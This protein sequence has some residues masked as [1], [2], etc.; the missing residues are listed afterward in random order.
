TQHAGL[1]FDPAHAPAHDA[2]AVDHR[3]VR[4]G[5]EHGVREPDA[6]LLPH[7]ARE[8]LHVDLVDDAVAGR[9]YAHGLERALR[10]FDESVTLGVA[11]EL[12]LLV[13]LHRVRRVVDVDFH[14]VIHH[15]VHRHQ[16]LDLVG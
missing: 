4:V 5:A 11:L 9:H 13:A 12:D 16:R 7:A 10:P 1:G 15:H 3:R 14:R 6:V 2:D 8:I